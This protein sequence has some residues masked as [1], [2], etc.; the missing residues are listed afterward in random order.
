MTLALEEPIVGYRVWAPRGDELRG[1][2]GEAWPVGDQTARCLEHEEHAAP[3]GD[4]AC[5]VYA[6]HRKPVRVPAGSV[7]GAVVAWGRLEVHMDGFRAAHARPLALARA[8]TDLPRLECLAA[9][10][11]VPLVELA[12]LDRYACEFGGRV[13][14][15]A[16]PV[17]TARLFAAL[18]DALRRRERCIPAS[19][20]V[21]AGHDAF[22]ARALWL[23]EREGV[24]EDLEVLLETAWHMD[25]NPLPTIPSLAMSRLRAALTASLARSDALGAEETLHSLHALDRAHGPVLT[26]IQE[27]AGRHGASAIPDEFL[28]RPEIAEQTESRA[29]ERAR[30]KLYE[31]PRKLLPL[32]GGDEAVLVLEPEL[33]DEEIEDLLHRMRFSFNVDRLLEQS[34]TRRP[35]LA[36]AALRRP[37]ALGAETAAALL[38]R[39]ARPL[40][41][42]QLHRRP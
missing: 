26:S 36:V 37:G 21:E 34:R 39:R 4:C 8:G 40:L 3:E 16:R 1:T 10:Y 2:T 42:R 14:P 33:S 23:L 41:L 29:R 12:V 9:R 31:R 30:T 20:V 11:Q 6:L 28:F 15:D 17:A 22:C 7:L 38:G 25:S 18:A 24:P 19:T 35:H 32:R 13:P 5:G 27:L